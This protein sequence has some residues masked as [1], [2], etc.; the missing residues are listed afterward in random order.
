M[1]KG[2]LSKAEKF[3]IEQNQG[4]ISDE[5]IAEDL[6]RTLAAVKK[7]TSSIQDVEP[8]VEDR[9]APTRSDWVHDE[10]SNRMRTRHASSYAYA[11]DKTGKSFGAI[12]T[13][14]AAESADEA[15]RKAEKKLPSKLLKSVTS[16]QQQP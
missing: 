5:Q 2:R 9:V 12:M 16:A 14:G 13:E 11:R 8:V 4:K 1:R 3:Y 6:D 7:H 15:A 10:E